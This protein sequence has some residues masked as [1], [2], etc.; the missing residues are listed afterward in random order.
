MMVHQDLLDEGKM[1]ELVAALRCLDSSSSPELA[2]R[3]RLEA[4]YFEK[5]TERMRYPKFRAQHLF[6]GSGVIE[7]GCK[8]VIGSRCKQ[9][10]MFWGQPGAQNVLALRCIHRSR[11]LGEFWKDRLNGHAARNDTLALAA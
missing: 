2:E 1:E 11:R 7:A 9:S 5:N 4:D 6:V 8:T 10:G 3:I